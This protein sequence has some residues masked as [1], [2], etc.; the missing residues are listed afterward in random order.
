MQLARQPLPLRLAGGNRLAI[1]SLHFVSH[2]LLLLGVADGFQ[3]DGRLAG[4][5]RQPASILGG[6]GAVL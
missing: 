5:G 1:E 3:D 6:V 2:L 4:Q